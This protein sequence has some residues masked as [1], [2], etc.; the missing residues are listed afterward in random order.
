MDNERF[1]DQLLFL[2]TGHVKLAKR[3]IAA[4]CDTLKRLSSLNG[5]S[6]LHC[7]ARADKNSAQIAKLL[8]ETGKARVVK[9]QVSDVSN[10]QHLCSLFMSRCI[11]RNMS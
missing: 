3:C 4:G 7:A 10:R 11:L 9:I 8:L 1:S 2:V 5:T 6:A